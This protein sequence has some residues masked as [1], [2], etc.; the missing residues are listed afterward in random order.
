M[1]NKLHNSLALAREFLELGAISKTSQYLE[2]AMSI[3]GD[4]VIDIKNINDN[5]L[6]SQEN[7]EKLSE[8]LSRLYRDKQ[9]NEEK[10]RSLKKENS[11]VRRE[12]IIFK[13]HAEKELS[14]AR[15]YWH[16]GYK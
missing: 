1:I 2:D 8:T 14:Q 6:T 13:D 15:L 4:L 5:L 12:Y 16:A 10:I 11:C 7:I 3:V 9:Q